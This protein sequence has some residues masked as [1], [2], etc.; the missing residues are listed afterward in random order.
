PEQA[1]GQ[2]LDARTDVFSFGSLLYEMATGRPAF[3]GRDLQDT[4]DAVMQR[5]P[6]P[7]AELRP[8]LPKAF[9]A[10]VE[11][12]LRKDP[13]ER[14]Q[15]M[16][17]VAEAL[18]RLALETDRAQARRLSRVAAWGMAGLA[19]V[20]AALAVFLVWS[21][22]PPRQQ[23]VAVMDF[24]NQA[25]PGDSA[26]TGAMLARLVSGNLSA[27]GGLELV[28]DKLL[29]DAARRLGVADAHVDR[30]N[31]IDV[32]EKAGANTMILGRVRPEA[33]EL[34]AGAD[35][36][37]IDTG[38]TLAT[39]QARGTGPSG[40]FTLADSLGHQ[41]RAALKEPAMPEDARRALAEQLTTSVDAY[42]AFVKG[43]EGLLRSDLPGAIAALREA[44][45]IDPAFALAQYRLNM[46]L[47]WTGEFAEADRAMQRTLAFRDKL[48]PN[49]QLV[50]DALASSTRN[51]EDH[52]VEVPAL[53]RVLERDPD[54][55]DALYSLGEIYTHSAS[56]SDSE[57]AAASYSR[58]L[59]LDPGLSLVYD[60]ELQ[61]LLRLR[62]WDAARA[63]IKDWMPLAPFN[64]PALQGTLALWEGH[65]DEA[66]RL[67]PDPL[68]PDFLAAGDERPSVKALLARSVPEL[69]DGLADVHGSYLVLD[70]DLR[71][72]ILAA[73]G[74]LADAAE[75]ERQASEVPG[76]VS[77]DGFHTSLRNGARHRLGWLLALRGD[78]G[79]ARE[80]TRAALELQPESYRC[81]YMDALMALRDH[82]RDTAQ[83]RLATLN[84]LVMSGWSP[85]A[86]LYRDAL[87]AELALAD[88]RP[89]EARVGFAA[90]VDSGHLME[91]W[92]VHEDSLG[93][94][95]RDGLARAALADGDAA[96]A[97]AAWAGLGASGLERLRQPIP[98]VLSLYQRGR[99]ALQAGRTDEGRQLLE[100][101]LR[102]WG[103]VDLPEVS[104][105]RGLLAG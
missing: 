91:D 15:R 60:H 19:V 48:P 47:I 22:P 54:N 62:R 92:Y 6:P 2:P 33:N 89:A 65:F 13:A 8:D 76:Q 16:A 28:S 52:S 73:H 14:T 3:E 66:A 93:P 96:T 40:V 90:L 82:D 97:E 63:Q 43:L 51:G 87:A 71:A 68:V 27:G 41:I 44:T 34:V 105:A 4:L 56:R 61:A 58:L 99:L 70:L 98:W 69:V 75:L 103:S 1:R 12:A 9:V 101:F 23:V 95:V 94:W 86:A 17:D 50:L 72:N 25:D 78:V 83:A 80:Q 42:R 102:R 26:K 84:E 77:R 46:A 38:Q 24:E 36:V 21:R 5:E 7:L 88:G 67:L 11:Q 64:L 18:R 30:S 85:A 37:D 59:A 55:A 31:A 79:A 49:L 35:I 20:A 81:L 74:R 45:A 39:L 53:L 57:K 32:A 100:E 104:D 29:L 10:L